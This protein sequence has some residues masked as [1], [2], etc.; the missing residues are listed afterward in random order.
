MQSSSPFASQFC[1][2]ANTKYSAT[3][4]HMHAAHFSMSYFVL[5]LVKK[6]HNINVGFKVK[7]YLYTWKKF[8]E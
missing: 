8:L 2:K 6:P 1:F 4:Y 3:E 5:I 7:G